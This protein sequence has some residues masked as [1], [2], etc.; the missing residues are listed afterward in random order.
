MLLFF[1][2]VYCYVFFLAF[3]DVAVG[4]VGFELVL[5][6]EVLAMTRLRPLDY[7]ATGKSEIAAVASLLRNGKGNKLQ[8]A[9]Y[10]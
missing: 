4:E 5:V 7:V 6:G 8:G 10:F 1:F 3:R 9:E 2:A